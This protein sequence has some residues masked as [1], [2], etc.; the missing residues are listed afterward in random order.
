VRPGILD[1]QRVTGNPVVLAEGMG[2]G[3]FAEGTPRFRQADTTLKKLAVSNDKRDESDRCVHKSRC[4][5]RQPVKRLLGGR[6]QQGL[7]AQRC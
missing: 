1:K 2:Q 6:I 3:R 4:Q 7:G 5:P